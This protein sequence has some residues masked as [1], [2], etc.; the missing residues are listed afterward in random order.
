MDERLQ[1]FISR[2][3]TSKNLP[4]LPH[5]LVKLIAA[6]RDENVSIQDIAK[7]IRADASLSAK[8]LKLANSSYF[9]SS[10]KIVRID[11]ALTRMGRDAVKNLAISSAVHQVFSK[12]NIDSNGFDVQ[13]FWRHSLT[14][15]VLSRMIAEKSGYKLPELAFLAGMIHDIGRLV[16]VVNFPQEYKTV[17]DAASNTTESILDREIRMGAPHTE[18]GAWLLK[19]WNFDTLTIDAALYHH[20]PATRIKEAFPLV[21]IVY[22]ANDLSRI[23]GSS[24]EAFSVLTEL[25]PCTFPE[26]VEI[27]QQAEEEVQDLAKFLGLSIGEREIDITKDKAVDIKTPELVDEVNDQ[28]LLIGILQ[29]L[30]ASPDENAILRSIQEGFNVLFDVSKIIF[31]LMDPDDGLL[32]ASVVNDERQIVQPPGLALSLHN[33]ESLISRSIQMNIPLSTLASKSA[34]KPAILDE[35]IKNL[36]NCTSLISLPLIRFGETV[37]AIVIGLDNGDEKVCRV[38]DRLLKMYM[39]QVCLSLHIE[40]QKQR[41]ARKIAMERLAATTDFARKVVHEANNPLGI[42]K[43]YLKILSTRMEAENPAQNEIRV[44]GEEI[45]RISRILKE[46]SDFSKSRMLTKTAVDLHALINDLTRIISQSLPSKFNIVLHTDLSPEVP[47]IRSDRDGLKQVFVNLLK[48][49][50]EAMNGQGNI[51]IKTAYLADTTDTTRKLS[52]PLDRGQVR[53]VIR[54]DGPGISPEIGAKLFE[55]YLSTKGNGHSG[56]GL[57]VVYNMIKELGGTVT[58]Q[59]ELGKGAI[60]TITLPVNV[61]GKSS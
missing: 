17:L 16:L 11:H 25:F 28:A 29:N 6:C 47:P 56:I 14:S 8:V 55:P 5:V 35:Q 31:F 12:S 58:C 39:E 15:A 36:L 33:R 9:R 60:F 61:S 21:K 23:N 20:E 59:S 19:K 13:R 42:I 34:G 48:N 54:D 50:V 41:E 46:L 37:G 32:K 4:S 1:Q 51:Y 38:E 30:V 2:I 7:I 27:I 3:E 52:G 10:E 45:D 43:N 57:S 26:T 49:A 24:D 40:K 22:A 53:V 18:I 44:I